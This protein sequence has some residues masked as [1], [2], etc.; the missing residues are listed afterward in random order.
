MTTDETNEEETNE[1]ETGAAEE[2][3]DD[4]PEPEVRSMRLREFAGC[5]NRAKEVVVMVPFSSHDEGVTWLAIQKNV[6]K[7]LID[8]AK[9]LGIEEIEGV[10]FNEEEG[11][12][13]IG[14]DFE[15][16]TP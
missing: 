4:G 3:P 1:E 11:I 6:A 2:E 13:Y 9:E 7:D 12:L 15:R 16:K 10:S 8:E 14:N 5:V